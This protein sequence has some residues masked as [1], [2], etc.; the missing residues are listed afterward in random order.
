MTVNLKKLISGGFERLYYGPMDTAGFLIGATGTA[1]ANGNT[2]GSGMAK[3]DGVKTSNVTVPPGENK[4][5]TGD[6]QGLGSILFPSVEYPAF[7]LEVGTMDLDFDAL[8]Q[9]TK[10]HND[11]DTSFGSLQ[12]SDPDYADMCLVLLRRAKGRATGSIGN[13]HWE[14]SILPRCTIQ[15]LGGD[16]YK[17]REL[18]TYKYR[19]IANPASLYPWG[20]AFGETNNGTTS[21]PIIP[22]TAEYRV[23][24][25]RFSGDGTQDD[26]I[27][28]YTPAAASA[29]KVRVYVNGV[30]L[31]YSTDY[32]VNVSTKTITFA[33][34]SIPAAS[35]KIVVHYEHL[36]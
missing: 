8:A 5:Q 9:G 22:L 29:A 35:A 21:M 33:G 4:T 7:D 15:P 30:K 11:G 20:L 16:G 31:V 17:E 36:I 34:G 28:D 32:T 26:F 13:A 1:P 25:Q 14:G 2:N 19:V 18:V 3:L 23:H 24:I 6:D 27:L 10:V 12:P